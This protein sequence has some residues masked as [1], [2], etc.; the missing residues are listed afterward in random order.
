MG[1]VF[2]NGG[3]LQERLLAILVK[4]EKTGGN[5]IFPLKTRGKTQTI[6]KVPFAYKNMQ[7]NYYVGE[8]RFSKKMKNMLHS[9]QPYDL[10][11]REVVPLP[12]DR[13]PRVSQTEINKN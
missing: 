4:L 3:G 1:E 7:V 11:R 12:D 6:V 5:A 9:H 13:R 10:R 2:K 8:K